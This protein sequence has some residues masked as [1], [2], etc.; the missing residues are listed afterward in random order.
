VKRKKLI[1]SCGIGVIIFLILSV[2]F[3]ALETRFAL[4]SMQTAQFSKAAEEGKRA[5]IVVR[6]LSA[7]TFHKSPDIELWRESL[8]LLPLFQQT[9]SSIQSYVPA[10]LQSDPQAQPV[11]EHIQLQLPILITKTKHVLTLSQHSSLFQNLIRSTSSQ[12]QTAFQ[13]SDQA[14]TFLDDL[15]TITQTLFT[16]HHKYIVLLQNTQEL[17]ATGGFMGS[18]AVIEI[19]DGVFEHLAIQDIYQPD[20]QITDGLEAPAGIQEYLS[21]G[22][23]YRLPNANWNPDFPSSSEDILRFFAFAKEHNIEGVVSLNLDVMQRVLDVIGPVY[24]PD[25]HESLTA[26][27]L[28]ELARADRDQFFPG[29]QQKKNFLQAVFNHLKL[30]IQ[31]LPVEKQKQILTLIWEESQRKNIQA[32]SHQIEIQHIFTKYRVSGEM[33]SNIPGASSDLTPRYLFL[34]ESNVGINKAN[35]GITREVKITATPYQTQL[36][37]YF[38]NLNPISDNGNTAKAAAQKSQLNGDKNLHYVN[39]QRLFINAEA[40]VRT[41]EIED[42]QLDRWDEN[43]ITTST[44]EKFKQIGFLAPVLEHSNQTVHLEVTY[45]QILPYTFIIQKQSGLPTVSYLLEADQQKKPLLLEH[46]ENVTISP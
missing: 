29:S 36:W 11:A 44:G 23:G 2:A 5:L 32:F 33:S 39:Y 42:K 19:N 22:K 16:G 46:D 10:A 38:H 35:K 9:I 27:N 7:L 17:R 28:P 21:E 40:R 34:V 1:L 4:R 8:E 24:L 6:P 15:N 25:Y 3:A 45:P 31:Q 26:D 20:G 13:H 43:L 18:Y 30:Q 41:I 12:T 14:I 37:I